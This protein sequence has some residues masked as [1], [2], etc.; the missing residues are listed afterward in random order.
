MILRGSFLPLVFGSVLIFASGCSSTKTA[1]APGGGHRVTCTS[2]MK[3]CVSRASKICGED[4]YTIMSGV[5]MRK[6][7]GGPNSS[8]KAVTEGGQI[9][10]RC[11]LVEP[12]EPARYELPERSDEE[13]VESA[14]SPAP[15]PASACVPGSSIQC[16][17]P[18]ACGGG[19]ICLEDGS[20]YGA[21]DCGEAATAPTTSEPAEKAPEVPAVPG[22]APAAEPLSK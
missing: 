11:G 18:G 15:A 2:G 19:Q 8:Y 10:I 1:V 4:G 17:G 5:S 7:L 21:C 6:V 3:D 13:E 22:Q 14:A 12:E 16:V 9:E 20:G